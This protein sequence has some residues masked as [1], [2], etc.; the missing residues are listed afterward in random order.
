[1]V[2]NVRGGRKGNNSDQV[3]IA[4]DQDSHDHPLDEDDDKG[5]F[6]LFRIMNNQ[7]K[8]DK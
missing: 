2:M 7:A 6:T 4:I 3:A 1:M 8:G 5:T